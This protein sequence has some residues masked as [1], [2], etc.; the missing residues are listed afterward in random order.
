MAGTFIQDLF[1]GHLAWIFFFKGLAFFLAFA[2]SFFFHRDVSLRLP[3]GWFRFF[4]LLQALA[5]W[6]LW[7]AMNLG[8]PPYLFIGGAFLEIM[9]W[10]CLV[11]LGKFGMSRLLNRDSGL[12]LYALLLM[13]TALSGLAGW[14]GLALTSRYTLGLGGGLWAAAVL[15]LAG[16]QSP[17]GARGSSLAAS[18]SLALYAFSVA[19][20][21]PN[22]LAPPGSP[23]T[24]EAFLKFTG[25]PLAFCQALLALGMV[26][27]IWGFRSWRHGAEEFRG[28]RYLV[29]M[30]TTLVV[31]LGLASVLTLWIGDRAQKRDEQVRAEAQELAT[32]VAG[33]FNSEFKR[34]E[35]GVI[36]LAG[37]SW[38]PKALQNP[39]QG[40]LAEINALLDRCRKNLNASVCYI[41][42]E[43][44]VTIASSNRN[45]P[46]SFVGKNYAYRP[47]FKQAISG[48]V[49]W[50]FA[51]GVRPGYYVSSPIRDPNSENFKAVAVGKFPLGNIIKEMQAAVGKDNSI[52][53]L[54]DPRGVVFLSTHPDMIF[55][56]VWPVAAEDQADLKDQYGKDHY[57]AIF[58][59]KIGNGSTVDFK[60]RHYLISCA[61]TSHPG[62]SVFI[63]RPFE[64]AGASRLAGIGIPFLLAFLALAL[65]GGL[66]YLKTSKLAS[67]GRFQAMF[68]ASPEATALIH[69][70]TL[71]IVGANRSLGAYL[72]YTHQELLNLK[73]DTLIDQKPQEIHDQLGQIHQESEA[74]RMKWRAHKKD[75][76]L[77]DLEVFGSWLADQGNG[78]IM[79]FC[80]E[81]EAL[82]RLLPVV[83]REQETMVPPQAAEDPLAPATV[84][85]DNWNNE[86]KDGRAVP[87]RPKPEEERPPNNG[88]PFDQ[89]AREL[90]KK[91][92]EA[93]DKVKKILSK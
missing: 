78:Q 80:R 52:V 21:L 45:D 22:Y 85:L 92:E 16:R 72:G 32:I 79:I 42:G 84:R 25:V 39:D 54:V 60:G 82:P 64:P 1:Q 68:D 27:G 56:S 38:L 26:A 49:G 83:S 29:P 57:V 31:I 91:I 7:A 69:P 87:Q 81:T 14:R 47:Y 44:G 23:F 77:I 88:T 75:G 93:R 9:S 70:K 51:V 61:E 65:L 6:L 89:E 11:G 41:M 90:V 3:W 43:N 59:K 50:Y 8:N 86:L 76:G 71:Q 73:L 58:P 34:L 2:V 18:M 20:F 33:R 63:F 74:V 19:F 46:E 35:D 10:M 13:L 30:V 48:K 28:P 37:T 5:A 15:F 24:Q 55:D 12:W 62:W 67:T 17:A 36:A 53:C 4:A 66:F 40:G